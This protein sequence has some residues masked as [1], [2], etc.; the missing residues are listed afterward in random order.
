MKLNPYI[1]AHSPQINSASQP[2]SPATLRWRKNKAIFITLVAGFLGVAIVYLFNKAEVSVSGLSP[3]GLVLGVAL[4]VQTFR[5]WEF[6]LKSLLVVVVIEGAMRKWFLPSFTELVYLYKD[7]LVIAIL[8]GYMKKQ[9]KPPLL[10]NQLL[11]PLRL[12][13]ALFVGYALAVVMNPNSPHFLI[14]ILGVKAY[15]LYIPLTFVVARMFSDKEKLVAFLKWYSVIVLPVALIGVMQFM[16]SDPT[17]TVNRYAWRMEA[18]NPTRD[19]ASFF[20]SA[21][22]HYVRITG[23]FSYVTG[24]SAYLPVMFSLLLGLISLNSTRQMSRALQW[25]FY[26][27]IGAVIVISFMTGSRGAV[28]A[29]ALI[30][31]FF[32]FFSPRK[33]LFRRLQQIIVIGLL[34]YLSFTVLF[35]QA[36]DAFYTRAFSAGQESDENMER[37]LDPLRIPVDEAAYAGP[38]GYGIGLTQNGV[39]AILRMLGMSGQTERLPVMPES[40]PGRVMLEVGV[41]GFLFYTLVRILLLIMLCRVCLRIRDPESKAISIAVLGVLIVQVV[42]GG[43]IITHTQGLYQW[44]LAGIPLALLNAERLSLLMKAPKAQAASG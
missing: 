42:T 13:L 35:P 26:L 29:I 9:G 14:P 17:S 36:Y 18:S 41:I 6:G 1:D 10:V 5:D 11:K 28:L 22:S 15:C 32:Y 38:F 25:V 37:L 7:I 16:D 44:V 33:Q 43:A 3:V 4:I 39:P 24:L 8:I 27:C 19:V 2:L 31:M 34:V 30:A 23:T 12:A 20:D 40:E 21:G